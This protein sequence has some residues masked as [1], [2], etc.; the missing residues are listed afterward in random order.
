MERVM[1]VMVIVP[2]C[3]VVHVTCHR[4]ASSCKLT[5]VDQPRALYYA[6][7]KID[8][9]YESSSPFHVLNHSFL[10]DSRYISFYKDHDVLLFDFSLQI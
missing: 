7:T 2:F 10:R 3:R 5:T 1:T 4:H 8:V 9:K 6:A